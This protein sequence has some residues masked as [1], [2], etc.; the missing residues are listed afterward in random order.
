MNDFSNSHLDAQQKIKSLEAELAYYKNRDALHEN[1]EYFFNETTD[2]ICIANLDGYFL[3]INKAFTNTLGYSETELISEQFINFVHPDDVTKTLSELG[4]LNDGIN[5]I[6]FKNRYQK[7]D[8]SCIWLQWIST[9]N[10]K[11][12]IIFAV[13][14]DVTEII[15]TQE[16]LI[17]S[18]KLLNES[19][20]MAGIGSWEF[21]LKTND[22]Y[23]SDE[24]Y[25][26]FEIEKETQNLYEK[27]LSR[28]K[29]EDKQNLEN[30]IHNN[31]IINKTNY[32]I[33]HPIYF[34]DGRVKWI[35]GYGEPILNDE[36]EVIKLRGIAKDI[37][38]QKEHDQAIKAKE[39][40]E[41]AS[42]AKTDFLANM[43][44]EIRTPLNGII[45]FSDLLLKTKLDSNQKVYMNNINQSANLLLD[46]ITDILDFS[47]IESGKFE[48]FLEPVDIRILAN[49]VIE[50]FKPYSINKKIDIHVI[51]DSQLPTY[52]FADI[53]RL[54]QVLVNLIGNAVKFTNFGEVVL[55][56]KEIKKIKNQ[57]STIQFS[58][59]DTGIGIKKENLN[60]IFQSFVQEDVSTN[61][62]FGGTGLGLSISN[63]ILEKCN[64][65]IEVNS[66][67]SEGSNFNFT[68][69]F[70]I[71]K[72]SQNEINNSHNYNQIT[73][74]ETNKF[75]QKLKILIVEDNMINMLLCKKMV[76]SILTNS[77]VF[78]AENGQKAIELLEENTIDL[79]LLDIQMPIKNGYETTIE[80][81]KNNKLKN[82]PIIALT[83][84]IMIGEK[85][86]CIEYGMDDYISKPFKLLELKTII[87]KYI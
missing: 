76:Q 80:I 41:T 54:K 84:G 38:T 70:K 64:S 14:R 74:F 34:E 86:K 68:I 25:K 53:V 55:Q 10:T 58:V 66:V 83:A 15:T 44:H 46:I 81:R 18:E 9:I 56:I 11:T 60:K 31:T 3:K 35:L 73:N 57:F 19:Q 4:N 65:K 6:N 67:Y 47:K 21:D 5:T 43:S 75:S 42:Q 48:L 71:A 28:F 7:K 59:I 72:S 52:I 26:I 51:I 27:Y 32:D 78:E 1:F 87:N 77:S 62:K 69:T 82:L 30:T 36:G 12:K 8:G 2:L 61:K 13:A 22:L 37:T 23:W 79:I 49:Q 45:G 33:E 29:D 63:K 50:L 39:Y 16:K 85:E 40:A 24:L 17:L 20:K